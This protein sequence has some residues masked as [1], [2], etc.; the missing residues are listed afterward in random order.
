M[1]GEPI[2]LDTNAFIYFFEGR[3]KVAEYILLA[4]TIYY[5]V[6]SEIELLSASQLTAQDIATIGEFLNRCQRVDLTPAIVER[7]ITLRKEYRLKTPDAIIASSALSLD[8]IL[9]TADK[10]MN[11]IAGL[12]TLTDILN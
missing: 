7:A 3:A 1:N 4:E 9:I 5:S 10:R 12:H 11:R 8:V 6:I 2:L